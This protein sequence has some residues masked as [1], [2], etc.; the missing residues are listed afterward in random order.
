[1]DNKVISLLKAIIADLEDLSS[2]GKSTKALLAEF[3]AEL[4]DKDTKK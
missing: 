3:E 2:G 4:Q 1:M